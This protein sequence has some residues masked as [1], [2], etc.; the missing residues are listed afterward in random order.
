MD[1]NRLSRQLT[2][3]LRHDK[4]L[5]MIG[6]AYV[7]L[8]IL[9]NRFRLEEC[10]IYNDFS[11]VQELIRYIVNIDYKSRFGVICSDGKRKIG[12]LVPQDIVTY[13]RANQG[14]SVNVKISMDEIKEEDIKD[15]FLMIHGTNYEAWGKI[16]TEGLSKM[17]RDYIHFAQGLPG[18]VKSGMRKNS[19]VLIYIDVKKVLNDKI[20]IYKSS[21]GVLLCKGHNGILLPKYFS[22][23]VKL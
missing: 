10:A 16:K 18:Q 20:P 4:N 5:P 23:V 19:K 8:N 15:S 6:D 13:L 12:N 14:H 17:G 7:D 21:N 11:N 9:R 3:A 1:V 2:K 22:K